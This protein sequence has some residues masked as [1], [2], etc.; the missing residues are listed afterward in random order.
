MFICTVYDGSFE[1]CIQNF[2]SN[3]GWFFDDMLQYVE[4]GSALIPVE[5]DPQKFNA[6]VA[7]NNVE[8][9]L[10]SAY[11]ELTVVQILAD[12]KAAGN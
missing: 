8:T 3:L 6:F 7:K 5:N 10:F 1:S 9:N 12:A 11:P 4:G 2:V